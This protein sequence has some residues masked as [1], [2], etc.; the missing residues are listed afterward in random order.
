VY[1]Q[2]KNE[3]QANGWCGQVLDTNG[4]GKITRPW[5]VSRSG[6]SALYLGDTAGAAN[7]QQSTALD[8][9]LDTQVTYSLYAVIPSPV[10]DSVWGVSEQYPG[11]LVRLQRGNNPPE[12]CKSTSSRCPSRASTRAAWTSTATAWCGRRWPRAATWPASTCASART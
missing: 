1:D 8:P 6:N 7:N 11:F 2:T 10:D 12:S 3:Q 5:N 4:D 9:K